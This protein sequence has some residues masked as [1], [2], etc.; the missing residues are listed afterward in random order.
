MIGPID[1]RYLPPNYGHRSH[2]YDDCSE[3]SRAEMAT[4]KVAFTGTVVDNFPYHPHPITSWPPSSTSKLP[5][6]E[7]A[8]GLPPEFW[9]GI[10]LAAAGSTVLWVG[11]FFAL[12]AYLGS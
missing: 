11:A 10:L 12:R 3:L 6:S 1:D 2:S 5:R 8:P 7:V 9:H 4:G